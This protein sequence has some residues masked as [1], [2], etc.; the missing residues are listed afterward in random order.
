MLRILRT[1]IEQ[2]YS[3]AIITFIFGTAL[4]MNDFILPKK[5]QPAQPI[6]PIVVA[7]A[8]V[9][10]KEVPKPKVKPKPKTSAE[11]LAAVIYHEARGEP[12]E[13]KLAVGQVVLNRVKSG[14]FPNS[15]CGV[16]FQR[17]QFTDLH[18]VKYDKDT[19]SIA[20]RVLHGAAKFMTAATHF[21]TINAS[22]R[23]A[24]SPDFIY[25]GRIGDHLF[26]KMG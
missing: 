17:G 8:P 2:L 12:V 1:N 9:V 3:L 23:W 11:C 22:P 16:A 18:R 6:A 5:T 4:L 26:Y 20:K 19:M 15:I 14:D 13:G 21:H 24:S 25:L 10:V 7:A